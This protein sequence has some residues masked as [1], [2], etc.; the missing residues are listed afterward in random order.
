MRGSVPVP[1]RSKPRG[2]EKKDLVERFDLQRRAE[3]VPVD[4]YLGL[5]VAVEKVA[6][7][8]EKKA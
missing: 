2:L 1:N 4:E 3:E 7:A 6:R 8:A 5:A